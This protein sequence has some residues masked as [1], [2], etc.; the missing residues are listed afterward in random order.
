MTTSSTA[1]S[2]LRFTKH[3]G[4]G[5]DFLVLIDP[6]SSGPLAAATWCAPCATAASGWAP[7]G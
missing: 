6:A 3:H 5:N 1:P 7:T 2:L 4:A